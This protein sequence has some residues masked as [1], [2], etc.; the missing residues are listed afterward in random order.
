MQTSLTEFVTKNKMPIVVSLPKNDID[1]AK[2]AISAGA[3]A[4]KMHINVEHRA[5]GNT[6]Y[7]TDYYKDVFLEVRELYEGPLGIV[8][9][10][11]INN[12]NK[13]DLKRLKEIGFTYFSV[14]EKDITSNLLLQNDLEKTVAVNNEFNI[15][16]VNVLNQ[17]DM[18]VIELS[19]VDPQKYGQPLS[20]EDL[21]LYA[22]FRKKTNL[23]LM[24]PSQKKMVPEDLDIIHALG[25]ESV[26]LG[27]MTVGTTVDSIY[28]TVKEFVKRRDNLK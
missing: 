3:D 11:N 14:Y 24:I 25:I 21:T 15:N 17:F 26:M 16:H 23:P 9:G 6:F 2:A 1:M 28:E 13:V 7:D 18:S 22:E 19:I 8:L 10:D 12:I 20:L 27:A 4:I 5:S